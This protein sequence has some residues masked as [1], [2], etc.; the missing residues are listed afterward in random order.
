[1]KR[2]IY[3][4]LLLP[5]VAM[6]V[7]SC[8]SDIKPKRP[9]VD[10]NG[11]LFVDGGSYDT[12]PTM[13]SHEQL[14]D[15]LVGSYWEFSYSFFYDDYKIGHKGEDVYFSRFK[16]DYKSDGTAVAT[17]LKDGKQY[18][19]TYTVNARTVT[20]KGATGT[21]SFGVKGMDDRHMIC[22]ESLAGQ[23]AADYDPAT[24]TRRMVFLSRK[25]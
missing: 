25:K 9:I 15:A 20:L 1:M 13:F 12:I 22:D 19:Y 4:M 24:L 23:S 6:A 14:Q 10:L 3:L 8:N 16:Y 7:V 17:D 2:V 11:V 18:H 21:F 5:V